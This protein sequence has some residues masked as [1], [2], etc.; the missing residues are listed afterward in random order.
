MKKLHLGCYQK[1]IHG[2]INVDIRDDVNPDVVDDVFKLNKFEN[3]SSDLIYACHVL[4]H[5]TLEESI[6]GL[7]RW[8][9]V[10]KKGGILR[11]AVPDLEAVFEHYI[12]HK[13]LFLLK[14]FIYG[15][16][17]HDYDYHRCGWDEITITKILSEIGFTD[18]KRYDWKE[19][20]H[21]Y[22]DDYSQSY[23]PEIAY[24]SR[25]SNDTIKG[26]LMSLNIEAKK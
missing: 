24:K 7:K 1:K 21:Y 22:I 2:F 6:E 17:K 25:R 10:L 13:D 18:I 5:A 20:E 9:E 26:K 23:L 15:S 12:F 16:Q 3:N 8:F 11:I 14:S 19:T 4:E